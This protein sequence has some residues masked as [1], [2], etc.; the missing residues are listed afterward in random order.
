MARNVY[1]C[2]VWRGGGGGGGGEDGLYTYVNTD[3]QNSKI[4]VRGKFSA[5]QQIEL[6]LPC[7]HHA[8]TKSNVFQN[9]FS[10]HNHQWIIVTEVDF[11]AAW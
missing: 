6:T 10:C 9:R 3:V 4:A 2:F 1:A 8:S 7:H 5:Q 11:V